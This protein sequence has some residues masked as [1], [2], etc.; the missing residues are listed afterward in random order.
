MSPLDRAWKPG[1]SP[2][3]S[4]FSALET[5]ATIIVTTCA[6]TRCRRWRVVSTY[7]V[8]RYELSAARSMRTRHVDELYSHTLNLV[9][10][11]RHVVLL[12]PYTLIYADAQLAC[13]FNASFSAL[14]FWSYDLMA[15]Y[16]SVYYYYYYYLKPTST[17]P[18]AGKTKLHIQN[19]GCNGN[20]L[21][22]H[23]VVERNRISSLQSHGKALLILLC[24]H[25]SHSVYCWVCENRCIF[26]KVTSRSVVVSCTLRAWPTHC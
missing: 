8:L 14:R 22:Y 9:G 6:Q 24:V 17:K 5:F 23:G 11:S 10:F 25:K 15:L 18:Q 21:C 13:C 16:K 7:D 20:L 3:T 2:D 1:F 19:Y 12:R 26:G 4:V